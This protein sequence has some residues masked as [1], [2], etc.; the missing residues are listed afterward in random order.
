MLSRH[1]NKNG[2]SPIARAIDDFQHQ[3]KSTNLGRHD[4]VD[5][6]ATGIISLAHHL[7]H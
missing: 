3:P 6:D 7:F 1:L 2:V 5:D 4:D